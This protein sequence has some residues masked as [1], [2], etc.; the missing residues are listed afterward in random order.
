M[1]LYSVDPI[2]QPDAAQRIIVRT[3]RSNKIGQD[4][5]KLNPCARRLSHSVQQYSTGNKVPDAM[6]TTYDV[7][8]YRSCSGII[9]ISCLL[10]EA[11]Y[12]DP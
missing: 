10:K 8:S 11:I 6:Q 7:D 4:G 3:H 2:R 12:T 1:L 9:I 5:A